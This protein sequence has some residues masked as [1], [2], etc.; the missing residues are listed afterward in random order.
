MN[1]PANTTLMAAPREPA[2]EALMGYGL[3]ELDA[4]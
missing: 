3:P 1:H 2:H 4:S